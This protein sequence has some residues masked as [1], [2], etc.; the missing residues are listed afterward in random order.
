MAL[1]PVL[2]A[3]ATGAVAT[4][5]WL[6][7]S[8]DKR[9]EAAVRAHDD[10]GHDATP[11][12]DLQERLQALEVYRNAHMQDHTALRSRVAQTEQGLQE[13]YW[14]LVGD[15]AAELERDRR[16]RA[17]AAREA[18]ERFLRYVAEGQSLD[19]A[20]RHALPSSWPD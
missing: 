11:H 4:W 20:Y 14:W 1:W 9:I 17:E 7:A 2:T 6:E 8:L 3:L 5:G 18:R 12:P 13:A 10:G 15:K 19:E 16:R